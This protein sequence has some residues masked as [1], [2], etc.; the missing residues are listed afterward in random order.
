MLSTSAPA[1]GSL[2]TGQLAFDANTGFY[3]HQ[4]LGQNL[5]LNPSYGAGLNYNLQTQSVGISVAGGTGLG[6]NTEGQLAINCAQLVTNC[7]LVTQPQL[8]G[9][10]DLHPTNL[11]LQSTLAGYATD[12]ELAAAVTAV[13]ASIP[14]NV[15][16]TAGTGIQVTGAYPNI[17]VST[18]SSSG[19]LIVA[20]PFTGAGTAAS[21]LAIDCAALKTSCGL[22]SAPP[23]GT[24]A[25]AVPTTNGSGVVTWTTAG[26]TSGPVQP[27]FAGTLSASAAAAGNQARPPTVITTET[28]IVSN[29]PL[30]SDVTSY[31]Q[32][33]I[34]TVGTVIA[35]R[36]VTYD[37][38][39]A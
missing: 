33:Q 29:D 31:V 7:G 27:V 8:Q 22:L 11:Q 30:S 37:S 21:P 20:A 12:A 18:T 23:A 9:L 34:N 1:L 4:F 5:V 10:L 2:T 15:T 3:Y 14:D 32:L 39:G 13:T 16:I 28:V 26:N 6:F 38:T 25:G 19:S 17:V 36:V 35:W 24:P